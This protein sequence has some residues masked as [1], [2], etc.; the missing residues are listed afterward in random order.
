MSRDKITR[1]PAPLADNSGFE[2]RGNAPAPQVNRDIAAEIVATIGA[3]NLVDIKFLIEPSSATRDEIL[4]A[5][6]KWIKSAEKKFAEGSLS[7]V[8]N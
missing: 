1:K 2:E 6:L 4:E 5:A 8:S 3:K 7:P